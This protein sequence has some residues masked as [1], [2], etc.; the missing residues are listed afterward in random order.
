M[1]YH[2]RTGSGD[3]LTAD[4]QQVVRLFRQKFLEPDDEIRKEGSEKW[5][6]L[7]DIPEYASMMRSE[8]SDVAR[9]KKIFFVT[10]LLACLFIVIAALF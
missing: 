2:I 1:K 9:F 10:A 6:K 8:K 4:G 3:E 5:R 7:R